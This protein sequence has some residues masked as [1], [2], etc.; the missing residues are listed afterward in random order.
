MVILVFIDDMIAVKLCPKCNAIKTI[1]EFTKNRSA[2]DGLSHYCKDCHNE[3]N[4]KR[5]EISPQT[6]TEATRRWHKENP[7]RMREIRREWKK[8]NPEKVREEKR[9]WYQRKKARVNNGNAD[10][11]SGNS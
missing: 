9:R 11:S 6:T 8:R 3:M 10:E 1:L 4:A 7:E 2:R 5:R